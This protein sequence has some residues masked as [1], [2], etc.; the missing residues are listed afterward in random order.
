M[1]SIRHPHIVS[2][3]EV[4]EG[5]GSWR[6]VMELCGQGDLRAYLQTYADR[7][8]VKSHPL[9]KP[10]PT[11]MQGTT[12][13]S[14]LRT[15]LPESS[16]RSV[17]GQMLLALHHLHEPNEDRPSI[18][19]RDIKPE[20]GILLPCSSAPIVASLRVFWTSA[21]LLSE[22]GLVKL[23]DLGFATY[24]PRGRS[25][26][27]IVGVRSPSTKQNCLHP[28]DLSKTTMKDPWLCCAGKLPVRVIHC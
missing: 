24:L 11:L 3:E 12:Y 27:S 21:V 19:H 9:L 20:N 10:Y 7:R 26:L 16:I 15:A 18:L 23:A 22:N 14:G 4:F 17:M 13:Y 25:A 8:Y 1:Q 5:P 28:S 6:I 2:I